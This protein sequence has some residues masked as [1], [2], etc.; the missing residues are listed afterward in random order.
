MNNDHVSQNLDTWVLQGGHRPEES[1]PPL[2]AFLLNMSGGSFLH[3]QNWY[4]Q[5]KRTHS[6]RGCKNYINLYTEKHLA[7]R[8]V[9]SKQSGI[10]WGS[11]HPFTSI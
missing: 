8:L 5:I 2:S 6:L 4:R 10:T 7:Q 1:G 3:L 9:Y 11:L